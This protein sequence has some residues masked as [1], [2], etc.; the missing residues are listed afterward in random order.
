MSCWQPFKTNLPLLLS[1]F[2]D[3]TQNRRSP[4]MSLLRRV[5]SSNIGQLVI[6]IVLVAVPAAL[7]A[8]LLNLIFGSSME[9]LVGDIFLNILEG[10]VI[11]VVFLQVIRR[12]E[13][14][15]PSE[16]GLSKHQWFRQLLVG[17]LGGGA[18]I[19]VVIIVLAITG[20]YRI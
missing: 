14:R 16:A 20:S 4:C 5:L 7:L 3:K 11:T 6:E 17:F 12:I 15:S 13:H 8:A 18:L 1:L 2:F 10:A 19:A 9:S